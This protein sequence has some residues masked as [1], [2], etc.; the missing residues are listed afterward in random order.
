MHLRTPLAA[1]CAVLAAAV[2]LPAT[3]A[4]GGFFGGWFPWPP[5]PPR[6]TTTTA[7][8]TTTAAT[9][10][11]ATT[12]ATTTAPTATTPT[13]TTAPATTAPAT[14]TTPA[15]PG[16]GLTAVEQS[17]ASA[18]NAARSAN[19]LPALAIDAH[20]EQAARDHTQELLQDG[21][22]TH[23]FLRNGVS[24][25]FATWIGWYYNGCAEGENIAWATPSL[26][27]DQAVQMWLN[28]PEHRANLLSSNYTV[29]GVELAG[30]N[31]KDIAT[32]DFGRPC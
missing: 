23:D 3:A 19:G 25:P 27:P 9:T 28:S 8:H 11:A 24:S 18:L 20:L 30:L 16:A 1:L 7:E 5:T 13:T 17:L 31:G 29:M 26:S 21:L 14:A 32:N 12:T 22:F 2:V 10:T 6:V 4:A 15:A